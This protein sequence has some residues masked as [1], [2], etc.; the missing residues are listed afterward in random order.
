MSGKLI[1]DLL[2]EPITKTF[3]DAE[4]RELTGEELHDALTG[5]LQEEV[6]EYIQAPNRDNK[7][8]ELADIYEVLEA[9]VTYEGF[10]KETVVS[11]KQDKKAERGGFEGGVYWVKK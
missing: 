2:Q 8:E 11:K 6:L 3:P 7:L 4:F 10:D 5:K 1:R 9:L